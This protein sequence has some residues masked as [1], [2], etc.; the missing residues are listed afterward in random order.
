LLIKKKAE[1]KFKFVQPLITRS[2]FF[3]IIFFLSACSNETLS[4]TKT[5]P[6]AATAQPDWVYQATLDNFNTASTAALDPAYLTP[7]VESARLG[8]AL[9][10]ISTGLP[11]DEY[12]WSP[13]VIVD[14]IEARFECS[15]TSG[16][17]KNTIYISFRRGM[18]NSGLECFHG[19]FANSSENSYPV[20][21]E[22]GNGNITNSYTRHERYFFWAAQ[23][24]VFTI[25][26]FFDGNPAST[27]F[28]PDLREIIYQQAIQFGLISGVGKD[29]SQ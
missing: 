29:C 26:E 1:V 14:S 11:C 27:S 12:E 10:K 4:L 28:S 24:I 23:G 7:S 19:F 2:T 21:E 5:I 25:V 3:L 22:S 8:D 9:R 16:E 17:N 20:L 15:K 13:T 6:G 18:V